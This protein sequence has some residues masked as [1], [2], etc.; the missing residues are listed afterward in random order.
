[1]KY[2]IDL[3]YIKTFELF[4]RILSVD[5][6]TNLF[7]D[8]RKSY[9]D[10]VRQAIL[11][12]GITK[13]E[14]TENI[15]AKMNINATQISPIPSLYD[16][17]ENLDVEFCAGYGVGERTLS[18]VSYQHGIYHDLPSLDTFIRCK[19]FSI[20]NFGF[21]VDNGDYEIEIITNDD[22]RIVGYS[23]QVNAK[24]RKSFI[25][26]L[27][28][29]F[30]YNSI[31]QVAK[32]Y[33]ANTTTLQL[34]DVMPWRTDF[35]QIFM[36]R[37]TGN[38]YVCNCFKDYIEWK[39]DFFRVA[40]VYDK[41][42]IN[43]L[44]NVTYLD[45]ICHY[46]NKTTPITKAALSGYSDFLLRY[47]PYFH[48][49]CKKRYGTIYH[50]VKEDRIN[51]ENELREYFGYPKIGEKWITETQLYN[52]VKEL[53]PN[54]QLLFHYRGKEMEGLE[55][56]IFI[57]DLKLGIEYQGEQHYKAIEPWGG[58]EGLKQ[59][60]FSDARKIK[61][62]E[63][64]N[65]NLVEFSCYD[66]IDRNLIVERIGKFIPIEKI[67]NVDI[68]VEEQQKN[69]SK[70][71]KENKKEYNIDLCIEKINAYLDHRYS[72]LLEKINTDDA[73]T[74]TTDCTNALAY[75]A[76]QCFRYGKFKDNWEYGTFYLHIYGP[77]L[78]IKSQS[79]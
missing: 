32:K 49:E 30:N 8:L 1:M 16:S 4:D 71:Q 54:Y 10:K 58:E 12:S 76:E 17:H 24:K 15:S 38:F 79:V 6:K 5:R 41:E 31:L 23:Y 63:N 28:V 55:L 68:K 44:N 9:I 61:L 65:Y 43:R 73:I 40:S 42:I 57:P 14:L 77:E 2:T 11:N 18:A 37:I 72:D 53:L 66:I 22:V 25:A 20:G 50:F 56:D 74:I 33:N 13:A 34:I 45:H 26:I 59:R 29:H 52:M 60:Q 64:N 70:K 69:K 19:D 27:G 78:I 7:K 67:S 46:C 48:L 36:C 62:C 51:L 47:A 75:I 39:D 35:P 21:L 3:S